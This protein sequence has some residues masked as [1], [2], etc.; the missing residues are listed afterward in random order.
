MALKSLVDVF[1][2]GSEM[3]L[4][5]KLTAFG[6]IF[7]FFDKAQFAFN[8]GCE[9][10]VVVFHALLS[11][12]R[13]LPA[14]GKAASARSYMLVE[15]VAELNNPVTTVT[16]NHPARTTTKAAAVIFNVVWLKM[17][18]ISYPLK[19]N[20]ILKLDCFANAVDEIAN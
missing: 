18:S 10:D 17:F 5:G 6:F 19:L 14:V 3:V 9:A 12:Q 16:S 13:I 20:E 1:M 8:L 15:L 2:Y 4:G 11:C 7:Q